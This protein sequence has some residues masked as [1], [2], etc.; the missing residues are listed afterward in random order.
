VLHASGAT[1]IITDSD[2]IAVDSA[3]QLHVVN[4][5]E[6]APCAPADRMALRGV[7]R[8]DSLAYVL[9]TSGS[10]GRPKGV[11]MPHGPLVNLL[12]WQATCSNG[13]ARTL[14]FASLGF[15]VSFQEIFSTWTSGGTLVLVENHIRR[16]PSALLEMLERDG[17]ERLFLP[18]VMLDYLAQAAVR[19]GRYPASLREVF[20]AGEALRITPD[21]RQFFERMPGCRLW[22]HY[23]PTETHVVTAHLLPDAPSGWPD[24]PPIGTPI[25]NTRVHVLDP[26]MQLAPIG[27][28]GDIWIGGAAVAR[29][30]WRNP[31]LT[32]E[33]FVVDP[34]DSS[35]QA[36]LYRTGDRGYWRDDGQLEF[37]GRTDHQVK[38]R[39]HRVE[40][41]EVEAVLASHP[42]VRAAAVVVRGET[43]TVRTL[44]G[45]AVSHSGRAL[46]PGALRAW[47]QA[48]LPAPMVPAQIMM[49]SDLPLNANGKVDR[50]VLERLAT[51]PAGFEH[52]IV[53]TGESALPNHPG[54]QQARDT[55][56][57]LLEAEIS[58][59]WQRLFN[60]DHIDLSAN[61]FELGGDSLS[62][63]RMVVALEHALGHRV[64]LATLLGAPTIES[65]AQALSSQAWVPAW[66]SL[67]AMQPKGSRIPLFVVHGM[68]GE[69][70]NFAELARALSPE[71]PVYGI[72]CKEELRQSGRRLDVEAMAAQYADEI[73]ALRPLGPYVLGGYSLGG[74]FAYAVATELKR[75]GATVKLLVFDTYPYCRSPWP[76]AGAHY[77][78][79]A[80]KYLRACRDH[81]GNLVWMKTEDWPRYLA[82]IPTVRSIA[83]SLS[84]VPRRLELDRTAADSPPAV[85]RFIQAAARYSAQSIR[86]EVALFQATSP[87]FNLSLRASQAMFWRLLVRGPVTRHPL[88]CGHLEILASEN[89]PKLAAMVDTLL[90]PLNDSTLADRSD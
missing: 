52:L 80:L 85:N 65:L 40:L 70:F 49:L 88:S 44:V 39:G 14:Q 6:A 84:L 38:I 57:T 21:I 3:L 64:P 22:N 66:S 41:G 74:W 11:A 48:R 28:P 2:T 63:V 1:V 69:V 9:Y 32:Q 29:G 81:L 45:Y 46:Q 10:T 4:P 5:S 60:R 37:I 75:R 67:V 58:G 79:S 43:G 62:A 7:S 20:I 16:D 15:D 86:S 18:V 59:I 24:L 56:R 82:G 12:E 36:R 25:T 23:G 30:Y 61:F 89:I 8:A 78:I 90:A 71:Q 50:T 33:R 31:L 26:H 13:R 51:T 42:E 34:F 27:T 53:D 55:S 72:R 68:M 76:A 35:P 83:A 77:L 73:I 47:L 87:R 19:S 17:M 54:D